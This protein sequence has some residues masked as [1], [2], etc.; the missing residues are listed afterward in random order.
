MAEPNAPRIITSTAELAAFAE[1]LGGAAR[2]A[3][4]LESN[5]LFVHRAR[6]CT[7]QLAAGDEIAIVDALATSIAPLG[8]LLGEHGPIKIVHDVSFD[9]RMLAESGV[10]LGNVHDTSIAARMLGRAATGLASLMKSELDF[11]MDKTLQHHDWSVRPIDQKQLDYLALDVAHLDALERKLWSEAQAKGIEEE[12]LE[13]TRY[14]LAGAIRAST[15]VDPQPQYTRMKGIERLKGV[16]RA[17][18]RRVW[19]ARDAQ[20]ARLD[21]PPYKVIGNEAIEGLAKARPLDRA[22]LAKVRGATHGRAAAMAHVIL[23]AVAIGIADGDIPEEDRV[24]I[25]RPRLAPSLAKARRSREARVM[26]WRKREAQKRDVDEQ[27]V[28]PGH[29]VKEIAEPEM[30]D[31]A[32]V[33]KVA[34]FGACR[35]RYAA[36]IVEALRAP[37]APEGGDAGGGGESGDGEV[38]GG[39]SVDVNDA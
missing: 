4:D 15:T 26:G 22:A 8:A 28:L 18:A 9:A 29:C 2:V 37:A 13:E 21:V 38:R 31:E 5:G 24:W 30:V 7:L 33:M 6:T 10:F 16:E 34:G 12:I 36:E 27:V 39:G 17:V 11:T 25:D 20:A 1:R 19:E 23:T 3:F 32:S 14:R 35:A